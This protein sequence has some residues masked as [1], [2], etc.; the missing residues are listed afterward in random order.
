M[1]GELSLLLYNRQ[2]IGFVVI[3]LCAVIFV[4]IFPDARD[5]ESGCS[6]RRKH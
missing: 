6:C 1:I 4:Y 5:C 2:T 3:V